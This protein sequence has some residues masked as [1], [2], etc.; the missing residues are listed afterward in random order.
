[1]EQAIYITPVGLMVFA[2]VGL[3]TI[4]LK[5][6]YAFVPI[7]LLACFFT[8]GERL[9]IFG[10]NFTV[11]RMLLI[12]T[13][14]RILAR[15]ELSRVEFNA[16]DK[17]IILYGVLSIVMNFLLE[18]T[19]ASLQNRFGLVYD[20]FGVYFFF[21]A[22]IRDIGDVERF[23]KSLAIIL[24]PL[25]ILMSFEKLTG[26]NLFA[27]FGGVAE[28]S[29]VRDGSLRVQ[30]PF[31]HPI[32]AGTF[33]AT[34]MP[35]FVG[36]WFTGRNRFFSV[37]GFSASTA[38][39]LLAA[40]SGPVI[41]YVGGFSAIFLWRFRENMRAIRW[42]ILGLLIATHMAMKAP[43]WYLIG[44]FSLI[45]GGTGWHRS[46]LIDQAVKH[47][48]EWWLLGTTYTAHWAE[49]S[50]LIT[51]PD[52]PNMVDI[53][54]QYILIG[55]NG[56][57]FPIM[58]FIA[59]ISYGFREV[60]RSWRYTEP[61][62]PDSAMLIWTL[63]CALL[64]HTLSFTSVSYFDQLNVFWWGLTAMIASTSQFALQF[65]YVQSEDEACSLVHAHA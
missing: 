31:R 46:D 15:K 21:R 39:S 63:G 1:M 2:I 54:S 29:G 59:I 16:V 23:I 45:F 42:S 11:L 48:S 65:E 51:L 38:I 49:H 9:L 19:G 28:F 47:F 18:R 13:W 53:T 62:L 41:A 5:R 17:V 30:G 58:A 60:G 3:L 4:G 52:V 22:V 40:S 57:V 61:V 26:R 7:I 27:V 24:F 33:G 12:V 44:R 56:G 20:V 43:I 32:L 14:V 55:V 34:V 10:F 50:C 37:L 35:F 6:E 36:L 25:V 8:L 64:G